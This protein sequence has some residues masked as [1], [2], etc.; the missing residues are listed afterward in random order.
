MKVSHG[1]LAL[2]YLALL[3]A[4]WYQFSPWSE[5]RAWLCAEIGAQADLLDRIYGYS[6]WHHHF[7]GHF[8]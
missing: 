7:P 4:R 1:E 3:L 6:Q 5:A 2:R 8:E